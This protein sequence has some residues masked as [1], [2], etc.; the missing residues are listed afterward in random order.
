LAAADHGQS[1]L[2]DMKIGR[3]RVHD[4]DGAR[5][6]I[7]DSE[8]ETG[9][10]EVQTSPGLVETVVEHI[11]RLR[12]IGAPTGPG[13]HL[14]PSLHGTRMSYERVEKIAR[15]AATRASERLTAEGLPPLPNTTPHTLRRTYIDPA[16]LLPPARG[17]DPAGQ[18]EDLPG[19]ST[20]L[21]LPTRHR[22][23]RGRRDFPQ[24]LEAPSSD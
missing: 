20:R 16:P 9:M 23:R 6:Q 14:V 13:D 1:E 17:P 19:L 12:R 10:R 11:D 4:P 5:F 2:C 3:V 21:P 8:T 22:V 24:R 15:D 18:N 7:P